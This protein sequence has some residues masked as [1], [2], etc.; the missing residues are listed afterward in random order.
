MRYIVGNSGDLAEIIVDYKKRKVSL[1]RPDTGTKF[2]K[3][4]KLTF[5]IIKNKLVNTIFIVG[6]VSLLFSIISIIFNLKLSI[7]GAIILYI[8][9]SVFVVSL[10]KSFYF[11]DLDDLIHY[12]VQK[13]SFDHMKRKVVV[14]NNLNSKVYKLPF[15]YDFSNMKLD[16]R[17]YGDFKKYLIKVHIFPED[18]YWRDGKFLTKQTDNWECYIYFSKIPRKGKM[19]IEFI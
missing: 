4:K 6:V 9:L 5:M 18:Y 3:R 10:I 8:I 14:I 7:K 16:C 17:C 15:Q 12:Y 13:L 2:S 11:P 19:E 1:L